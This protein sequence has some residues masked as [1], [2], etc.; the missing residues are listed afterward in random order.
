MRMTDIISKKRD[1]QELTF[2][3]IKFFIEGYVNNKIP[4]YQ[5]SAMLMAI[6]FK[7]L[8]NNE[9]FNLTSLMSTS[10]QTIDLSSIKGIKIDKHSTGGVGDKTTLIVVPIV[11]SLGVKVAKMSGRGLGHTGGTIDKLESIPGLKTDISRSDFFNIVNTVGASIISQSENIV[12]ADKKIYALRD[13]T[14]TVNSVPLIASSI[15]SKKIASGSDCILLDVKVGSG[16]FMKNLDDAFSISS[17]MVK[18]GEKFNKKTIALITNMDQPLGNAIGNFLEVIEACETLKGKGPSDLEDICIEISANMLHLANLGDIDHCK[19]LA[20]KSLHDKTAFLKLKEI[21]KAQGGDVSYLDYPQNFIKDI[22]PYKILSKKSGYIK[23]I[24]TEKCGLAS[25]ILGA[26]RETKESS[27]DYKSGI[28]LHKKV[29]D[30]VNLN[31]SIATFY[32]KNIDKYKTAENIFLE[33]IEISQ[34]KPSKSPLIY[35]QVSNNG[36]IEF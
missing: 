1:G 27:I 3:D 13:A 28:I 19:K 25:M 2:E 12:P 6:Y 5:M 11:A 18:I 35:A 24:N 20:Y 21:V 23:S 9:T 26:G 30:F 29:G 10:G 15:M 4:D 17:L 16:A 8:S 33:S 34:E 31:D 32:S 7:G 14:S 22:T 36:I